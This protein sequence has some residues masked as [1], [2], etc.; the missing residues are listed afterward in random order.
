MDA[1]REHGSAMIIV[2]ALAVILTAIATSL[3]GLMHTDITHASI[4]HAKA[5]SFAIA[6]AGLAEAQGAV[7]AAP[8]PVAFRNA[9]EGT[10]QAYGANGRFTYWIDSGPG[11][12]APCGPGLK[13]LESHGEVAYLGRMITTRVRA[14]GIAGTPFLTAVFGVS[15]VEGQGATSRTYI[16]PYLAGTP[17][18]PRGGALGSFTEINFNDSGLRLNAVSETTVD[19]VALRDGTFYD[20]QL[21]GFPGRPSYESNPSSEPMPWITSVFGDIVKAQPTTG[22]L[23]NRCATLFACVTVRSDDTDVSSM[24]SLR[25]DEHMRHVYMHR[26]VQQVLP[27]LSFDPAD[28]QA[29]AAAN[30]DNM[31]INELAGM[32]QKSNSVYTPTEFNQIVTFLAAHCPSRC[33]RGPVYLDGS[34]QL[35]TSVNLGGD[36]GNVTLG[37]RGD[38]LVLNQV[39]LTNRHDLSEVTGRQTPGILIFGSDAPALRMVN[40]CGG[41][42]ANGSGRL[43]L[44][45]GNRQRLTADGLIYTA[46]GMAV[47]PQATVDL[48]GAM[49]HDNRGTTNA[50]F[51]NQN[52]T[53]VVRF[54]P[55]ALGAFGRGIALVSWQQIR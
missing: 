20:Y 45:G 27:R 5:S 48:I 15:V 12:G 39:R 7:I 30:S 13:T 44:C 53:M 28:F 16:A 8:S 1:T 14:C 51:S 9:A 10:G 24:T 42:R 43:I 22:P 40:A 36:G 2:L 33:L 19:V 31:E 21:F 38:L 47:G 54:D 55:L 52:A 11:A 32:P 25:V 37:V 35:A 50:S 29:R 4:Q 49:Y 34:Y 26:M 23:A 17:G 46:D 3:V 6:Q 18:S 41:Q